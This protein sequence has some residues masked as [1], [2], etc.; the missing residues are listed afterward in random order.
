MLNSRKNIK[1]RMGTWR[2]RQWL[3]ICIITISCN[4]FSSKDENRQI[5]PIIIFQP[6]TGFPSKSLRDVE[7]K[8][9]K[10]FPNI[11]INKPIA[12]P[13]SG[14]LKKLNRYV[15]DSLINYLSRRT[16]PGYVTVG[17][18]NQDICTSLKGK[19]DYWRVF[20]L[21][22]EDKRAC[23]VSMSR[24]K[25]PNRLEKLHK[26]VLHEIGHTQ[27]L[28]HCPNEGCYMRAANGQ[29]HLNQLKDFCPACKIKLR[30]L[31]SA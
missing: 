31:I 8:L 20:G 16:K 26:L 7:Q 28:N 11:Q 15:A 5:Q 1:K 21:G 17:F 14:Y 2:I 19:G 24:L 29:D 4:P 10:S 9:R 22:R 6:F 13:K 3:F 12:H 27:G 25:G 30:G 23:I 18:T